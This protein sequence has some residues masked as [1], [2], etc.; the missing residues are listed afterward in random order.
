MRGPR[1]VVSANDGVEE[2][3]SKL[4]N[5]VTSCFELEQKVS[6]LDGQYQKRIENITKSAGL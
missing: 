6:D 4:L 2:K 3:R 5:C 1:T